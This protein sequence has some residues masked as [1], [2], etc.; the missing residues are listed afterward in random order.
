MRTAALTALAWFAIAS[1]V[2][3][4]EL[5]VSE[6]TQGESLDESTPLQNSIFDRDGHGRVFSRVEIHGVT[7]ELNYI[8]AGSTFTWRYYQ[9]E[10]DGEATPGGLLGEFSVRYL[11]PV[12]NCPAQWS[13]GSCGLLLKVWSSIS[14]CIP[15][16]RYRVAALLDDKLLGE[17]I[18]YPSRFRPVI[19][20]VNI[21]GV[22]AAPGLPAMRGHSPLQ[23]TPV[24]S[25]V[26]VGGIVGPEGACKTTDADW[27]P[28]TLVEISSRIEPGSGGHRHFRDD[29]EI[30]TGTFLAQNPGDVL[31]PRSPSTRD[32]E[33]E[34][35]V[36]SQTATYQATYMPGVFGIEEWLSYRARR[37]ASERFPALASPLQSFPIDIRVPDLVPLPLGSPQSN[38]FHLRPGDLCGHG[39]DAGYV[40]VELL[41]VLTE[42]DRAY[43]QRFGQR[44]AFGA[45]SLPSGGV[46]DGGA[47]DRASPCLV[48]HD[49]GL[50]IDL[51]AFDEGGAG[52]RESTYQRNGVSVPR[53]F[54]LT[55]TAR[56]INPAMQTVPEGNVIHLRLRSDRDE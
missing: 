23:P 50:D 55:S 32:T 43:R 20:S 2:D 18:F 8:P 19:Q 29:S 14:R 47:G 21:D 44:L 42:L 17:R 52:L 53:L 56:R 16:G 33:I 1:T 49:R 41:S 48:G 35:P 38:Q 22:R 30:G 46:I 10:V 28:G 11:G 5:R 45:A 3:A 7:S 39:E 34:G 31:N 6:L 27:M 24:V 15:E 9:D 36:E 25:R 4:I 51:Q 37:P 54:Y 40:S 13:D 26:R 12:G